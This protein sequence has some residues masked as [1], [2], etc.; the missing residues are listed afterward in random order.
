VIT[1]RGGCWGKRLFKSEH[2]NNRGGGGGQAVPHQTKLGDRKK[3]RT[4]S[5]SID[6][7]GWEGGGELK[8]AYERCGRN[9]GRERSKGK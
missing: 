6:L 7:K 5:S 2:S 9:R 4:G 8:R 3:K 1:R